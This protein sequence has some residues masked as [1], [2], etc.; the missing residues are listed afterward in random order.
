[1]A[2]SRVLLGLL[3]A[4]FAAD[5]PIILGLGNSSDWPG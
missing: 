2:V 4:V 1:L 3:V 5:G